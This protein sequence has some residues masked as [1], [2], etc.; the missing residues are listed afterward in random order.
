MVRSGPQ[1]DDEQGND[2]ILECEKEVL[3][4]RRES[5]SMPHGVCEVDTVRERRERV[6]LERQPTSR[7][8]RGDCTESDLG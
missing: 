1:E 3:P 8:R 2:D 6:R 5:E 7:A 4:V